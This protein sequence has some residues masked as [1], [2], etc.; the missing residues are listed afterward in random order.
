VRFFLFV[1][2]RGERSEQGLPQRAH[3]PKGYLKPRPQECPRSARCPVAP[4]GVPD[5]AA[6]P[7]VLLP[8][9]LPD[10]PEDP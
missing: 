3:P 5:P 6:R 1:W 2:T 10:L 4:M 8:N 9:P 7:T